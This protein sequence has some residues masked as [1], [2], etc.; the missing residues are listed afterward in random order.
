MMRILCLH[1][2]DLDGAGSAAIVGMFHKADNVVYKFHNYGW[3]LKREDLQGYDR[4]YAVDISFG[5]NHPWVYE[6][7]GLVWIDHHKTALEYEAQHPALGRI[8][9]IRRMGVGACELTW[10]YFYPGYECPDLIKILS[11]YDVWD[12]NRYNW[13]EVVE[14]E[15]GAK[16]L[17]GISPKLIIDFIERGEN[18]E[19]LRNVGRIILGYL[20]KSGKGKMMGGGFWIPNFHGFRVLALCTSDFSSLTFMSHYNPKVADICMPFQI[21]PD[22]EYPGGVSVRISLYTENPNVDVSKIAELY[23]GGGHRGAAGFSIPMI[24]LQDILSGGMSLKTYFQG[25]HYKGNEPKYY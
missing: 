1:H 14:I 4:I 7:P 17:I 10:E 3:P 23:G 21:V 6:I 18:L 11:T 12:K 20:E 15:V 2:T 5:E 24:T 8:L 19:N 16:H 13:D 9:G 25:I 22:E